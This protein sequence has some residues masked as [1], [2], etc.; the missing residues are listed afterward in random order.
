MS[1]ISRWLRAIVSIHKYPRYLTDDYIRFVLQR[2]WKRQGV[3]LGAKIVWL[4]KPIISLVKGSSLR[5][6]DGC[7]ICSRASQTALGTNHPVI[8]RT[9]K[10]GAELQI[11]KQV[12]MSGT[13]IC[14]AERVIIGDRCIIGAD[15]IITDTD[16]HTLDPIVRS[17]P[18][19]ADQAISEGVII[20]ADAFIGGRSIILKG[21]QI[22]RGAVIGAGSVVTG[23]VQARAVVAGNPA[24]VIGAIPAN[25]DVTSQSPDTHE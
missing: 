14:A 21:V 2:I 6:G 11:G 20:D 13:T 3:Q 16:F 22:G 5:I 19:D 15:V 17:S 12:R 10:P 4:G 24:R 25:L 23:H 18:D 7:L 8:L 1:K 9:L